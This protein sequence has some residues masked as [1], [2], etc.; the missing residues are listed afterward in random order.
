MRFIAKNTTIP[1]PKVYCAFARKG[2]VYIL[3][4]RLD[5]EILGKGWVH[6]PMESQ[7]NVL[8]QLRSMIQEMRQLPA[9]GPG[10]SN[11]DGGPL[12]DCRLPGPVTR[13]GPFSDIQEF[14][15]HLRQ[16][17]QYHPNNK[18][19]INELLRLQQD[20]S[21]PSVFTHGDLSSLNVLVRGDSIVGIIDWETAGWLPSYWEYTTTC[22][23]NP[24]NEFWREYIDKFLEPMPQELAMEEL[25]RK[26]FGDF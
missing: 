13:F 20:C 24:Q 15:K 3:M 21:N 12:F 10:I 16:D 4:E 1:V 19:E 22:Y 7:T 14:H 5:G 23:V 9:P 25:R 2:N 6:R 11:V 17:F 18:P 8:D 26:Y